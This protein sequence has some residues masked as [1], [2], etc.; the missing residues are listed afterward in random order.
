MMGV[1]QCLSLFQLEDVLSSSA[2]TTFSHYY[3][4]TDRRD[5]WDNIQEAVS[6]IDL[7]KR[8]I[9]NID[10]IAV[11]FLSFTAVV[12]MVPGT[13]FLHLAMLHLYPAVSNLVQMNVNK[14]EKIHQPTLI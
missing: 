6:I 13:I 7:Q 11:F 5:A 10:T 2:N 14:N 9:I 3:N 4:D 12:S 8:L 1:I